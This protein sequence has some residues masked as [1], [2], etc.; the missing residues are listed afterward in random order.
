MTGIEAARLPG[1]DR[2]RCIEQALREVAAAVI[3]PVIG[4]TFPLDQAGAAHAAIESR[5]VFGK[6][7]ITARG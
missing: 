4:Q 1:H 7:L 2:T 6:T 5:I 3:A